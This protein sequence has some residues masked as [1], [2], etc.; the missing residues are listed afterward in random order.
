MSHIN[1]ILK[2]GKAPGIKCGQEPYDPDSVYSKVPKALKEIENEPMWKHGPARGS[3]RIAKSFG[4]SADTIRRE[5]SKP[6]PLILALLLWL[7][8]FS[9]KAND[10]Q[11]GLSFTDGQTVNAAQ[12]MNL[13]NLATINSQFISSKPIDPAA[14]GSDNFVIYSPTLG[15]L[16]RIPLSTAFI[17]NTNL[18]ATQ[19]EK[20]AP[21]AADLLL[22]LDSATGMYAK[23][24]AGNLVLNNTNVSFST[25][26]IAT[27]NLDPQVKIPIL[28]FGTNGNTTASNLFS[29][30]L[31]LDFTNLPSITAPT[32][33]DA[34]LIWS[35]RT[36]ATNPGGTNPFLATI[37]PQNVGPYTIVTSN[38]SSLNAVSGGGGSAPMY[39]TTLSGVTF[40]PLVKLVLV[41][42]NFGETTLN[43]N[44]YQANGIEIDSSRVLNTN[45][46]PAFAVHQFPPNQVSVE[47]VY[48]T[49]IASE[50]QV[51]F[52]ISTN[53]GPGYFFT[54]HTNFNLKLY[55][56]L[57]H[58]Q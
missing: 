4:M 3:R 33:T 23:V 50:L 19:T 55:I 25:L 11:A 37:A 43:A 14:L 16:Y 22:L 2:S 17:S 24:S 27:T 15:G 31:A 35:T 7:A 10:V 8:G 56:T 51:P 5:W 44:G 42:T 6:V 9:A 36:N 32:N 20:T 47:G 49:N 40:P 1:E 57:Q 39:N 48:A 21:V 34:L 30:Q 53:K 41:F 58:G 29:S 28:N 13:V 52:L 12:L 54:S 45:G 26:P 46:L 18:I 38:I